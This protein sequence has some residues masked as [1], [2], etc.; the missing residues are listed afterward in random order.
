MKTKTYLTPEHMRLHMK[1]GDVLKLEYDD[2]NKGKFT[3]THA[4][5]V[6]RNGRLE[7]IGL[8]DHEDDEPQEGI[9]YEFA[10]PHRTEPKFKAIMCRGS[11]C[12]R[13]FLQS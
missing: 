5:Y 4:Q 8:F 13:V 7:A 11:G 9:L 2:F 6:S 3:Y 10:G 12:E 1:K